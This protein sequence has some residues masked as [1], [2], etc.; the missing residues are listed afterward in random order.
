MRTDSV[1]TQ[2]APSTKSELSSL[3]NNPIFNDLNF[4]NGT[5]NYCLKAYGSNEQLQQAR[6]EIRKDMD[7]G[8]SIKEQLKESTWLSASILFKAGSSRLGKTVF[9]VHK[10]NQQEKHRITIEKIKNDEKVY[11]ENIWKA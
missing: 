3:D 5:S 1:T 2:T 6:E 9:D 11:H 10:E 7:S 8:K 4:A